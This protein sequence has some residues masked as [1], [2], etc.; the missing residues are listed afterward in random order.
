M[1]RIN[2]V[3]LRTIGLL[4]VGWFSAE[5]LAE[6]PWTR[7]LTFNRVEADPQKSY[8]LTE[9]NGPWVIM[10]TSFSGDGAEKQAHDLVL[11]LRKRYKL[12]AYA[13]RQKFDFGKDVAG[14]GCDEYGAP[15]RMKFRR[16]EQ[17]DEIAVLVGDYPS[18]DDPQAQQALRKLKYSRPEC[19]ALQAE[20]PTT[21]TLAGWR[22]NQKQL[23]ELIGSRKKERGPMGHAFV[24]TNPL[25]GKEYFV[26][27]G[28]DKLVLKMNKNVK[29]SLLDCPGNYTVQ[30][31]RFK[32]Q[33]I[34]DQTEIQAVENGKD[35]GSKLAEAAI[36]A[37]RLTEAL[38]LLGYEAYEFHDRHASIV[39]VGSFDSKGTTQADGR[40]EINPQVRA[41][42]MT[43]G[44]EQTDVTGQPSGALKP[45]TLVDIN[46][47]IQ[48]VPIEVPRHSISSDYSRNA[49]SLW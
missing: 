25:L 16:G 48:P 5:A 29:H 6:G 34:L 33:S 23:Q 11:E 49:V 39:T 12:P 9:Q 38:R 21:Q 36:K 32:G 43:F 24:T 46:F 19:L 42:I 35:M 7:L 1:S 31:A 27:K 47:D 14:R 8:K 44:A 13:H 20:R 41:A 3:C 28:V 30:V 26:P 45:K 37:H 15:L 10:A 40:F 2:L 22:W 17:L 18:V 4:L